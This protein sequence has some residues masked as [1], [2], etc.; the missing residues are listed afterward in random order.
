[1]PARLDGDHVPYGPL[2][3]AL[4][5]L[6]RRRPRALGAPAGGVSPDERPPPRRERGASLPRR[7]T[8]P[9]VGGPSGA[10]TAGRR[11]RGRPVLVAPSLARRGGRVG[12]RAPRSP[13][14]PLHAARGVPVPR[15]DGGP[16]PDPARARRH[17]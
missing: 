15:P 4:L 7:G 2:A 14:R 16:R 17:G 9:R 1:G 5:A 12:H 3:A 11:S 10:R 6:A 13:C 8:T